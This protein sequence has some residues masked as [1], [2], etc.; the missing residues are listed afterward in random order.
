[1]KKKVLVCSLIGLISSF[2]FSQ[3]GAPG[4][5][6]IIGITQESPVIVSGTV[7]H[8]EGSP[9]TEEDADGVITGDANVVVVD[10]EGNLGL[11]TARPK[12]KLHVQATGGK[13]LRINDG[14][15]QEGKI[16]VSEDANGK[17]VW[18]NRPAPA[19]EEGSIILYNSFIESGKVPNFRGNIDLSCVEENDNDKCS[20]KFTDKPLVLENGTWLIQLKY[21]VRTTWDVLGS[22]TL[23]CHAPGHD[24]KN[25]GNTFYVWTVL[26][27][28]TAGEFLTT[29]GTSPEKTGYC[30]TTPQISHVVKIDDGKKHTIHAYGSTSYNYGH[31]FVH[32]DGVYGS[33]GNVSYGAP[34]FYA[35][36]LDSFN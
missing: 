15:A 10:T 9:T 22:Q 35:I 21:T 25:N 8:V 13:G 3:K 29:V 4:K 26:Y 7:L 30:L 18:G 19:R 20:L 1:M 34:Y 2:S 11:G 28:Q 14:T 24:F 36:R 6:G 32:R 31:T 16:A 23:G 33:Y 12:A 27:D 17:I 5:V